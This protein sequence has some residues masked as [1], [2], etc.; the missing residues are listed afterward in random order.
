MLDKYFGFYILIFL[1]TLSLTFALE[2][3]LIPSLKR[4]AKQPI[5]EDGPNWHLKKS[6]TPTMG[7]LAFL[8]ASSLAL[9]L[10]AVIGY[11]VIDINVGLAICISLL[12]AIL[13]SLI[14]V[15]DDISK[16]RHKEN[17]GLT[18]M[19]KLV[20]Q[21]VCAVVFL[22]L[23]RIILKDEPTLSFAFGEVNLGFWYY[24][25]SLLILVGLVNFANLTDGI[26]GL[27]SSVAF[28]VSI[29]L[30]YISVAL[31]IENSIISASLIGV[32]LAFLIFNMHPAKIFMGDTGSLFLGALIASCGF[33][34]HNPIILT[35]IC[36][37][38]VLEGIS[39]IIQVVYFK[40]THKR[41]FK[42]APFHHH[43][44]KCGLSENKICII[45]ILGTFIFSLPA[46]IFYLP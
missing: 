27:A 25:L 8:I 43:L 24:P 23:R 3:K 6:G 36:G 32:S 34:L 38:Y 45:A 35:F 30:F 28:S 29:S 20:L 1:L 5:Y 17:Q 7:G 18:P 10:S 37:V 4:K 12:Y 19:Q 46:Y 41:F 14:G 33:N 26:D 11:V 42:M 31:N 44:E 13:N 15:L 40:L 9:F 16:L 39:V 2:K 22:V 21:F